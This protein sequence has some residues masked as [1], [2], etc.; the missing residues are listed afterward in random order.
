MNRNAKGPA[1][2]SA[3]RF[4]SRIFLTASLVT[5]SLFGPMICGP[6]VRYRC[7]TMWLRNSVNHQQYRKVHYPRS[8][9]QR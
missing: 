2:A 8:C 9:S 3:R 1:M 7:Q 6:R 5:L 4:Q